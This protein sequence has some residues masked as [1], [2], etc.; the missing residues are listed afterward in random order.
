MLPPLPEIHLQKREHTVIQEMC[1][2]FRSLTLHSFM[3]MHFVHT[4]VMLSFIRLLSFVLLDTQSL[5]ETLSLSNS[6]IFYLN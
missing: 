1:A 3:M 2:L 4:F 5:E 6:E